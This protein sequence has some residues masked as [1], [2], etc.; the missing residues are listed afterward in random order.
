LRHAEAQK[1]RDTEE[2]PNPNEH[3]LPIALLGALV[4]RESTE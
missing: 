4:I 2:V 3:H 1:N